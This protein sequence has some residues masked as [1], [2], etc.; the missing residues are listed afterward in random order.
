MAAEDAGK[1]L[2]TF[3]DVAIYFSQEEWAMLTA[4]QRDLYQEVMEDN[5]E[6]VASLGPQMPPKAELARRV[7]R[8][9]EQSAEDVPGRGKKEACGTPDSAAWSHSG[10]E[11][12]VKEEFS[13]PWSPLPSPEGKPLGAGFCSGWNESKPPDVGPREWEEGGGPLGVASLDRAELLICECGRSFE[14]RESLRNHQALHREEKGPFACTSCGKLFHYHL[15][16]L[17]HKKHRGKKRHAC[18]QCGAQFC[19]KGDLLRHRASHAAEGLHSCGVCGLLFR[20]KRHLLA[21]TAEHGGKPLHECPTCGMACSSEAELSG[22][23]LSHREERPFLCTQCGESFSWKE[24]LQVHQQ[25]HAQARGHSCPLCGKTFARHGNLL[26]H[27]RLHTGE[28]PFPCPECGRSFPSKANL[29]AHSRQHRRGK[30]FACLQ[31]GH[32]FTFRDKLLE[33][34]ASH[35]TETRPIKQ[36]AEP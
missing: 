8:R 5:F 4:W 36:D 25:T 1:V 16:L 33:H 12:A 29:M 23:R 21:H 11:P 7:E 18:A 32:G 22:H 9:E 34:Q 10:Q 2:V 28:L 13:G 30:P 3:E 19:L 15:N 31:C 14:D 6:L 24:S 20:H 27:Q 17:T 26:T 35:G